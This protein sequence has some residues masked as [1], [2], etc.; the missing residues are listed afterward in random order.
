MTDSE[1][2]RHLYKVFV[3]VAV[4]FVLLIGILLFS[5]RTSEIAL[6][7][8][9][10]FVHLP[11]ER[12]IVGKV[13]ALE[14]HI[15]G[16]AST[17]KDLEGSKLSYNVDLVSAK[18]GKRFIKILTER[19]EVPQGV[20]VLAVDPASFVINIDKF[21]E[22]L[23][24]VVPD[25][26]N[27]PAPGY[28]VSTVGASPSRIRLMGAATILDTIS[29]VRTT[30]VDLAGLT[31]PSKRSVALNLNDSSGVQPVEEGLIEINI[32]VEEKIVE[33]MIQSQVRGTGTNYKYG[34]RPKKIKLLLKGPEKTLNK[35]MQDDGIDVRVDLEGLG[36]GTYLRHA[37]IE[38]PLDITLLKA[39][40]EA[41][42]IEIFN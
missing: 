14:A 12:V 33:R 20:S 7:L 37:I 30:P 29:A 10:R 1:P 28:I 27:E 5:Y 21:A 36:P 3:P 16:Y 38:P 2:R 22:K 32:E 31:E 9:V 42:M 19:I 13:P 24:P 26:V 25:L 11:E 6:P 18:P 17:L 40:P 8:S 4:A 41:F 15:R 39:K 34:I 23:V 35:L